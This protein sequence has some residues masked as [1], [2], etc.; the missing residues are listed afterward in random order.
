MIFSCVNNFDFKGH[1]EPAC[2]KIFSFFF[3]FEKHAGFIL[4]DLMIS[5]L[6]CRKV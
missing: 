2:W 1:M 6:V 3:V 5:E 4:L